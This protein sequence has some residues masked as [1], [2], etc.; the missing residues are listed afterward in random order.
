MPE[1]YELVLN[2]PAGSF[3]PDAQWWYNFL[4]RVDRER[5]Q[6]FNEDLWSPGVFRCRIDSP[7][8]IILW[9]GFGGGPWI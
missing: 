9:A 5:G 1:S 4:Y 3:E 6:D 7:T 2:C 8:K